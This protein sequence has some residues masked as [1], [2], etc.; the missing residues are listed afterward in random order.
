MDGFSE[1]F[2][3][4]CSDFVSSPSLDSHILEP[5]VFEWAFTAASDFFEGFDTAI[6]GN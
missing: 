5:E 2:A 3:V 1:A 4:A 6:F